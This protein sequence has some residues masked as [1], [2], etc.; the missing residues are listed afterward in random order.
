[1]ETIDFGMCAILLRAGPRGNGNHSQ[2][3]G[4]MLKDEKRR[5]GRVAIITLETPPI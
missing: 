2:A 5:T 1:M 4:S 3:C